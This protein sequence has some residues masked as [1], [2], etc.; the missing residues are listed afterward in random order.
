MSRLPVGLL[1][2]L[3]AVTIF[4]I[5]S[6]S[7]VA[8]DLGELLPETKLP[9]G[10]ERPADSFGPQDSSPQAEQTLQRLLATEKPQ[11]DLFDLGKR[12][13][14]ISD[15]VDRVVNAERPNYA[16][17]TVQRFWVADDENS[18]Y[19]QI[20]AELRGKSEHLYMYVEVGLDLPQSG[21]DKTIREFEDTIYPRIR[22][23]YG[24]E[25]SPGVDNDPRITILNA[26]IPG[27][28]GYYSS[29]DEFPSEVNP[30][31]NEREMFYINVDR[32]E[33][34]PGTEFYL[35]TLCHEFQHMVHWNK[36][37]TQETWLNE[38]A[39]MVAS[40]LCGYSLGDIASWYARDSDVQLTHWSDDPRGALPHYAAAYLFMDY[41]AQHYGGYRELKTLIAL[42][43][44][45]QATIDAYLA[46]EG[47]AVDFYDVFADWTA[48]NYIDDERPDNGAYYYD[49]R[50][51]R[52][53]P[54]EIVRRQTFEENLSVKQFGVQYI[55]LRM[56]QGNYT[57]DFLG[58]SQVRLFP[59]SA[60]SGTHVWWGNRSDMAATSL[61]REVDLRDAD[62][63]IL[64]FSTWYD[65][66]SD[67]DYAY[68]AASSDGGVTWTTLPGTSTTTEN[69]NGNN[70]GHG[71]T[72]KS[73]GGDIARWIEEEVSLADYA[74]KQILLRFEYVTDDAIN[75]VGILVD[76]F[77]I[78]GIEFGDDAETDGDWEARGFFRTD[79]V[80]PQYYIVQ[81][82][83]YV[84]GFPTVERVMLQGQEE[85][86]ISFFLDSF[87]QDLQSAVLIVSGATPITTEVAHFN[88]RLAP[89]ASE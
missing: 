4:V 59:T 51:P 33:Y 57:L 21:I 22:R 30:F 26:R 88:I 49:V 6:C 78:S 79:G 54:Q 1:F 16:L 10:E 38:G 20:E 48:A 82:V 87:G 18:T 52:M 89:V 31:S 66:E 3:L 32:V 77:S 58:A 41:F 47:Y 55:D 45:G 9:A 75:S 39:A 64:R 65:I 80:L 43:A 62:S 74:G 36:N 19:Y 73:G 53:R 84:D 72:G 29:A 42:P 34:G 40:E 71:F 56:P 15:N 37:P 70:L 13:K 67:F 24:E 17:G 85:R 2:S 76:D 35:S 69:P 12:Y 81:L 5:T 8:P 68:V 27:V 63:A 44:R 23:Y 61:T 11:R 86:D 28:G 7:Q 25:W 50:L 60:P 83:R 14:G 46:T